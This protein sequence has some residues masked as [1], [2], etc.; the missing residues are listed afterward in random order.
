MVNLKNVNY[1]PDILSCLANLSNDEVFTL[2][3]LANTVLDMLPNTIWSDKNAKFLD[4]CSKTGIFLREITKRLINGLEK[5][6]P[7]LHQRIN[8]ILKNQVYGISI[9]EI[10]SLL[11]RRSLYC[12]QYANGEYS[13]CSEFDDK[14]GNIHFERTGHIWEN[15]KCKI[16]SANK[17]QYDRDENLETHAYEF[18]HKDIK[19]IFNMKFDVIIGN[20]PYQLN[21]GGGTGSS[22]IP[23][24]NIF[25]EQSK[26]LNPRYL[27]MIIPS[28]WFA[29][30]KGLDKFRSNMLNDE[31]ISEI[32]D[33]PVTSDCFPGLNIRGGICYFL[34]DRQHRKDCKIVNH[35]NGKIVSTVTRPLLEKGVSTFVR[36][37]AAISILRKVKSFNE[38]TMEQYVSSRK[39]F[40]IPSNFN[41]FEINKTMTNSIRLYRFGDNGYIN[42]N[43]VIKNKDLVD[44]IKVIVSKAS[45]GGDEY[46]HQILTMPII[47]GPHSAC[48]ETYLIISATDNMK[49]ANN[50]ISYIST[51]FFR[52]MIS[53]I[54]N[55]QNISKSVYAF[56]PI[57][58]LDESWTDEKLYIKYDLTEEEIKFIESMVKPMDIYKRNAKEE[59]TMDDKN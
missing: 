9:T 52:F 45:P 23:L 30:G 54:K 51:R 11:T 32:H 41:D 19:E 17:K 4:P 16:C 42:I 43:Q 14:S 56:V 46:P 59:T 29:G 8:H 49:Q 2:P 44:K 36:Y 24:Y 3:Q 22:A 55:T 20:P 21:D 18:L 38:Q 48:S 31:R 1:N 35:K 12:S 40:G 58:N 53:L 47:A 5:E 34:W 57:Q 25:V 27:S 10:T 26:K 15:G 7:C 50:L 13:I 28:R 39:P 33:F 6:I 37:N